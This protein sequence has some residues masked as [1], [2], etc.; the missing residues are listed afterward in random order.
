VE[1]IGCR[2]GQISRIYRISIASSR[3]GSASDPCKS[4]P[5]LC[6]RTSIADQSTRRLPRNPPPRQGR[7]MVRLDAHS[8][9]RHHNPTSL[10]LPS[11]TLCRSSDLQSGPLPGKFQKVRPRRYIDIGARYSRSLHLRSRST[12]LPRHALGRANSLAYDCTSAVGD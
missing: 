5:T 3:K 10:R 12:Y 1:R 2:S 9:L 8:R 6:Y 11:H 7:H 4:I